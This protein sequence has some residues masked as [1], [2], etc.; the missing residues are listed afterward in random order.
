[1]SQ[2]LPVSLRFRYTARG[3]KL[4]FLIREF[5]RIY[6]NHSR[7]FALFADQSFRNLWPLTV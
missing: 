4:R 1:M 6:T 2:T 3:H 7:T 5:S